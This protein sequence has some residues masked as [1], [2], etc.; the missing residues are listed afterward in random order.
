MMNWLLALGGTFYFGYIEVRQMIHKRSEYFKSLWNYLEI[1]CLLLNLLLLFNQFA[2]VIESKIYVPL[3]FFVVFVMWSNFIWW[4]RIFEDTTFYFDLI[5]STIY[6]MRYFF[7][8][9]V[10]II[11]A[12]G[13]LLY[14]LNANR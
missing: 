2:Q 10:L 8:I 6:D 7:T 11:C 1:T 9:F 4:L 13:N 12:C 14:V 3:I 5:S